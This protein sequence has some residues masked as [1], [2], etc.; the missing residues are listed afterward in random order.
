LATPLTWETLDPD[1]AAGKNALATGHWTEA[2]A[3]LKLA[4]LRDPQ[5]AEIQTISA[6][7]IGDYG[8]WEPAFAHYRQAIAFNPRHRGARQH[9]GEAYLALDDLAKAEE[10]LAALAQ[11][12]LIPCDEYADLQRA[13]ARY[14]KLEPR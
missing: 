10:H 9:L 2:I 11:I 14:V 5:N 1:F 6:T 12:C 3:A 4:S 8:S 7:P 13:I